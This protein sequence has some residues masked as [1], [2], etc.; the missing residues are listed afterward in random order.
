MAVLSEAYSNDDFRPGWPPPTIR[1]GVLTWSPRSAGIVMAMESA[2]RRRP[3]S[4]AVRS[5][6]GP[7]A[8][9]PVIAE[10]TEPAGEG[11]GG[12]A[13]RRRS[14]IF[15]AIGMPVYDH[16][17]AARRE[18]MPAAYLVPTR[19]NDIVTLLRRQGI[20]VGRLLRP[21]TGSAER[22]AVDTL[23]QRVHREEPARPRDRSTGG[24]ARPGCPAAAAG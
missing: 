2:P 11:N 9:Q 3:D 21:W 12:Y 20:Q 24:F 22:F 6:L 14:G 23:Q 18:A 17:V 8:G 5:M 15:R 13:R 19:F 1:A 4:V 10:I 16:F 7:P